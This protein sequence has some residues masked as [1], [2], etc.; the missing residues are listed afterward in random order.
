MAYLRRFFLSRK[1]ILSLIALILVAV[2]IA[3]IVPQRSL[4]PP[5]KMSQWEWDNPYFA[6]WAVKLGLDHVYTTSW[7][8]VLLFLFLVSLTISTFEQ[9]KLSIKKTFGAVT[10]P[11]GKAIK[12]NIT[13]EELAV[14][15]KKKGYALIFKSDGIR[16]FVKNPWGYW[17]NVFFH[18]GI[19]ITIASSLLIV[20]TQKRGVLNLVEGE[21]H[22]PGKNKWYYESKGILAGQFTLTEAVRL[23]KVI[24]DYWETDHLKQLSTELSFID[25]QGRTQRNRIA[26]NDVLNYR[27]LRVYQ[28]RVYGHAFFVE[29]TDEDGGGKKGIILQIENPVRRDAAGYGNFEFEGVPYLIKAKYYADA[30][31]KS[32]NASDP[33]LVM[34]LVKNNKVLG[35]ISLKAA[36]E[37]SL[38]PYHVRLSH[39]LRWSEIIFTDINGMPGIFSGFFIIILGGGL[40]YFMPPRE[41]CLRNDAGKIYLTWKASRFEEFYIKEIEMMT[42]EFGEKRDD[43]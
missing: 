15:I 2:V 7:F 19:V 4:A 35:E 13:E 42:E 41:F 38:G 43:L 33:L 28:S 32:M 20:L 29:L 30:E 21:A 39:I 14:S 16:R 5:A 25:P 26:I 17:G 9:M 8:A 3:Y 1:T 10:P 36:Q 24:P 12:V 31:K 23:D 40:T 11:A 34:R 37:G 22:I 6:L 18:M 27:G